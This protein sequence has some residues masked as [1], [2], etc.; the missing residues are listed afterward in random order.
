MKHELQIISP[1]KRQTL[2]NAIITWFSTERDEEIGI[3]AA[4]DLLDLF[5]K[6]AGSEIYNRAIYDVKTTILTSH[7]DLLL[8]LE[9][10]KK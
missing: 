6:E 5:L 9:A 1:E 4:E 3:L 10:K 7:E 2:I 8:D